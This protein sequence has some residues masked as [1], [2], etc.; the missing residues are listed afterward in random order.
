MSRV[1]GVADGL[2]CRNGQRRLRLSQYPGERRPHLVGLL[3]DLARVETQRA[4][5][6]S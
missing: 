2:G 4:G 5:R 1:G 3:L 6:R